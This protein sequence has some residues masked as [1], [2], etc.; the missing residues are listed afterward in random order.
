MKK[1]TRLNAFLI[2]E[3][4]VLVQKMPTRGAHW[5]NLNVH[6]PMLAPA[7]VMMDSTE[8][9]V[10]SLPVP[11]IV[12]VW[13]HVI[14]QQDHAHA[15]MDVLE[16]TVLQSVQAFLTVVQ[17]WEHLSMIHPPIQLHVTAWKDAME[18][19]VLQSVQAFLTVVLVWEHLSMIH[20][21][22]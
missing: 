12:L 7:I 22:I 15:W 20:P 17:I 19:A 9:T 8:M 11:M 5:T 10:P 13:E 16:M 4:V 18:M 14:L 2:K 3:T 1:T 21:Q 6:V